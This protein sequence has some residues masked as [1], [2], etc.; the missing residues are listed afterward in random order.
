MAE[1]QRQSLKL[2][3]SEAPLPPEM[4]SA[5]LRLGAPND[6]SALLAEERARQG[7]DQ[8]EVASSLRIR[9]SHVQAI[10][11]GRFDDL[12]GPT[13]AIGFIRAYARYLG[14]DDEAVVRLFKAQ[15][16][17]ADGRPELVYPTPLPE[18]RFPGRRA[19]AASLLLAGLVYGGWYYLSV[20]ET[21]LVQGVPEVPARIAQSAPD[22][23]GGSGAV[24]GALPSADTTDV[25]PATV[26]PAPA[27]VRA[28]E[29]ETQAALAD[30]VGPAGSTPGGGE[31]GAM[32]AMGEIGPLVA[33]TVAGIS[34]AAAPVP[35]MD[36]TPAGEDPAANEGAA[37][38]DSMTAN[39]G[40]IPSAP[41]SG[42]NI[43]P[44]A[45]DTAPEE[46]VMRVSPNQ[47][48]A[49][50]PPPPPANSTVSREFGVA[51]LGLDAP[52]VYGGE[53]VGARVVLQALEDSWVQVRDRSSI[54]IL[55]RILR[56]GDSYHVPDEAGLTLLTGNAGGLALTVDGVAI[57][58]LGALGEVLRGIALEPD[59][60]LSRPS[61][62]TPAPE[63]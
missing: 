39:S 56:Q 1:R 47:A 54:V 43:P 19:V 7:V 15:V 34:P 3:A 41:S 12:P 40:A 55:T 50:T 8:R 4:E 57:P 37:V 33:E 61:V 44:V 52:R 36:D 25:I 51:S 48:A 35:P 13:Y 27:P 31:E 23:P 28:I 59:R 49:A 18:G 17:G 60:L 53:N 45:D 63:N 26:V 10:D 5:R 16:G 58:P 22:A 24:A 6:I 42:A 21:N 20:E 30:S 38:E 2:V 11:D 9:L 14:L 62:A 46:P 32:R 29:T